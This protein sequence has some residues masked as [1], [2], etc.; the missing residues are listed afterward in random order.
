MI[1][2]NLV[3]YKYTINLEEEFAGNDTVV[4]FENVDYFGEYDLK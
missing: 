4:N 3:N 2:N 1:L